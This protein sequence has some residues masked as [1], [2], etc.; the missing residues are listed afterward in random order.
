MDVG[1][2][3]PV[4]DGRCLSQI[5]HIRR[6]S[7]DRVESAVWRGRNGARPV[8]V[9][10]GSQRAAGI[11]GE[12]QANTRQAARWL[13]EDTETR[14]EEHTSELQSRLHLVCR[15]LLEKKKRA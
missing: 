10:S 11:A 13:P 3:R 12:H 1:I 8:S 2:R 7:Q 4:D 6:A 15:L 14:S 5:G 9:S